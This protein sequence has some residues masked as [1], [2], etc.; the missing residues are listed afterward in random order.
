MRHLRTVNGVHLPD[1]NHVN[2]NTSEKRQ[3]HVWERVNR[4]KTRPL[5]LAQVIR[6]RG[7]VVFKRS[8]IIVAEIATH[9]EETTARKH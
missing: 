1:A 7:E 3:D 5:S 9:E 4:V 8:G 2:E 6:R